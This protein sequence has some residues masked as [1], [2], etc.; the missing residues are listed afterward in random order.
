MHRLLFEHKKNNEC[1][2][3]V[4]FLMSLQTTA[5][6]GSTL[7][8]ERPVNVAKAGYGDQLLAQESS[9]HNC[10]GNFTF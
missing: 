9:S 8:M 10:S 4:R 2:F 3:P 5:V 7:C 1:V 6:Q